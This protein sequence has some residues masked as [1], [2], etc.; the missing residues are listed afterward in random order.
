MA[1]ARFQLVETE[2]GPQTVVQLHGEIDST[3]AAA[4]ERALT[5][6]IASGSLLLDLT[7]VRYIESAGF[8]VLDRVLQTGELSI[9]I[10][11]GCLVRRVAT[12]MGVPFHDTVDQARLAAQPS[13]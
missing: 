11:P 6:G 1:P 5:D 3:N 2:S 8:E 10:S 13:G 9:V 4:F 7:P 12:L